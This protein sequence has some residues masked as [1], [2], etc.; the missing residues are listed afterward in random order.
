MP[1]EGEARVANNGGTH[2][3]I[4]VV[5]TGIHAEINCPSNIKLK[6]K[7]KQKIIVYGIDYLSVTSFAA[8]IKSMGTCDPYK[9]KGIKYIGQVLKNK[10]TR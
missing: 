9:G 4:L 2:N 8:K 10:S 1:K 3:K 6:C 5:K 7:N